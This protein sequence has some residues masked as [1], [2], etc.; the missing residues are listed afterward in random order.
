MDPNIGQLYL[1]EEPGT[2]K[3]LKI[4]EKLIPNLKKNE[5]INIELP[6]LLK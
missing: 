5:R 4:A 2:R 3:L 1:T 6:M